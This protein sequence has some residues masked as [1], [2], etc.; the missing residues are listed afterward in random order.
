MIINSISLNE[1]I[2]SNYQISKGLKTIENAS[3]NFKLISVNENETTTS[4]L[5]EI[6][7]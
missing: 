1:L 6:Y 3:S 4:N 5:T 7:M 2:S